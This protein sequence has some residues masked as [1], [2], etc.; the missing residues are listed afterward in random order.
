M[1]GWHE[2]NKDE[3]GPD[4]I[5]GHLRLIASPP[6]PADPPDACQE[7]LIEGTTWVSLRRCLVCGHT[8]CCESSLRQHADGHF[9]RTGHPV[10]ADQSGDD[11]FGWCYA[12]GLALSIGDG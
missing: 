2:T 7:C 1:N 8:G 9:R 3:P 10:V 4:A 12:D 11:D 6:A 5:C